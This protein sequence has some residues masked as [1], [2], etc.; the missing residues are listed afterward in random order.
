MRKKLWKFQ[1]E[2]G[3]HEFLGLPD[4]GFGVCVSADGREEGR[5]QRARAANHQH[6]RHFSTSPV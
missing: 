4:W 5:H 2:V 1:P 3:T 6:L